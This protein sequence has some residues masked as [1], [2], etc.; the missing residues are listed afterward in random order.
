MANE[1]LY[2]VAAILCAL[3]ETKGAPESSLYMFCDMDIDMWSRLRDIMVE[4]KLIEVKGHWV[5]LTPDGKMHA[6][7]INRNI[8]TISRARAASLQN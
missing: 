8:E 2:K 1:L 5:T 7:K 4:S 6:E 3:E